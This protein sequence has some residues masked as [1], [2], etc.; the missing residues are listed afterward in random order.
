MKTNGF[1]LIEL[2]IVIAIIGIVAA[3]AIPNLLAALQKSKVKA[4]MGDMKSIGTAIESYIT[5]NSLAP[6]DGALTRITD[7][8]IYIA[9]FYIKSLPTKDGW[10]G[11]LRYRSNESSNPEPT[12]YSIIS[13]GKDGTSTPID[14]NNSGYPIHNMAAF[15]N[16]ICFS[17]GTFTYA[18]KIK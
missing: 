15:N 14:I 5:D 7:L 6:G 17:N 11:F 13:Y 16:D 1:T 2:I 8:N 9:P 4:T 12:E 3:I 18:S 10:G